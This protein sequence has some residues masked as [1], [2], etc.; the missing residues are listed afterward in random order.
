MRICSPGRAR[1]GEWDETRD[2]SRIASEKASRRSI[3]SGIANG[4]EACR[5][6][7]AKGVEEATPGKAGHKRSGHGWKADIAWLCL[8]LAWQG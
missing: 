7:A 8:S 2:A 6:G 5:R 1:G 4:V 3:E